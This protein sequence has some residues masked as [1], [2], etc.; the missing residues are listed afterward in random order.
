VAAVVADV[1]GRDEEL[2]WIDEF[3]ERRSS[4]RILL[5]EGDPGV[6]KSTLWGCAV[7]RAGRLG[8]SVR[9]V[10]PAEAEQH[11]TYA[12]LGDLL[13]GADL[14]ALPTPQ[15]H[16]LATAL[17]LED[18][19]GGP[20][21]ERAVAAATLGQFRLWSGRDRLVVGIDDTHWL[22]RASAAALSYAVRRAADEGV[23]FVLAR[24]RGASESGF[25]VDG[26][27]ELVEVTALSFGAIQRLV[28]SRVS[29]PLLRS[30]QRRIHDLSGGNPFFALEL[31]RVLEARGGDV[32]PSEELG[33]SD[34]L[35]ELAGS[36]IAALPAATVTA[37]ARVAALGEPH[38]DLVADDAALDP[39]F[40][41]EVIGVV[42]HRVRFTHPLLGAAAY[43]GLSPRKRRLL[44]L[45]LA[46]TASDLE[47][48]ARHL[49]LGSTPPDELVAGALEL[50]AKSAHA[51][52]GAVSAADLAELAIR[53]SGDAGRARSLRTAEA[54]RY[55]I[56]AGD[57]P[58]AVALLTPA[59]PD[60]PSGEGRARILLG[61]AVCEIV[62]DEKVR[63]LQLALAEAGDEA[64]LQVEILSELASVVGNERSMPE[65]LVYAERALVAAEGTGDPTAI[66]PALA[67][68]ATVR[69]FLGSG[70][71]EQLAERARALDRYCETLSLEQRP[72]AAF[73]WMY[74]WAGD[75]ERSRGLLDEAVAIGER[76]GDSSVQAPIFYR[77]FLHVLADEWE[78]AQADAERL[79]ELGVEYERD[80][81]RE[82]ALTTVAVIGAH[83]GDSERTRTAVAEA[84][85]L[86]TAAGAAHDDL[87]AFALSLLE[88]S[89]GRRKEALE[90]ARRST[91]VSRQVGVEEP[92]LVWAFPVHAE[93]AIASGEID[94]ATEL[95]AWV[96][97]RA[98]RLDRAWALACLARCRGILAAVQGDTATAVAEFER[99]LA[100]HGRVEGRRFELA[101]TRLA[102]GV[103]LRRLKRKADA[104][105]ALEDAAASFQRLGASLWADRAEA[106]LAR[107]SGRRREGDLTETERRV[108]ALV[109][110]GKSN[111]EVA[112]ELF[113]SV[114]AV[115]SNLTKIYGKL[116]IRSRT[117]LAARL[118]R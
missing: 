114:R 34:R 116:G 38:I 110:A 20:L 71:S 74:K 93:A 35:D 67:S 118:S 65:G 36:R 113:V 45:D 50:A 59:L 40:E 46:T 18:P 61:L 78:A 19:G 69:F 112:N 105:S 48:R 90:V 96:E 62:V 68:V 11:L 10:R 79:Y 84:T 8:Y 32:G 41:A 39:A 25:V 43:N 87:L 52:G 80:D 86:A 64:S 72:V 9:T 82:F 83:T 14:A 88:L 24:R 76:R 111:K 85:A 89:L 23:L 51:R 47:Q 75:I 33:L 106:E 26:A 104:R 60:A 16:A 66:A 115:E 57:F 101:R 53:F 56:A 7:A 103:A 29:M 22:D 109:A 58:R 108:A 73:G 92:A 21:D 30:T 3:L 54:A 13:A 107:V 27:A 70:L 44:H 98:V 97:E 63:Y 31:A 5:I 15:R 81:M 95:L 2:A 102:Q 77:A 1:V 4:A 55:A 117:E 17:L 91:A 37:L 12:A 28:R 49:A 94:E 99:A 42:A 6:G 100:E